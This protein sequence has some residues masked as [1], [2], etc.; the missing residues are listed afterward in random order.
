[1]GGQTVSAPH[2]V[3]LMTAAAQVSATDTVLDIGTA[4]AYHAA[5]PPRLIRDVASV[6]TVPERA[7]QVAR[8]FGMPFSITAAIGSIAL[9]G[10]AML[11]GLMRVDLIGAPRNESDP[12]PID[13]AVRK[14]ARDRLGSVLS[15]ALVASIGFV[16]IANC[17]GGEMQ[18]PLATGV[19][20]GI[21]TSTPPTLLL[22]S[23]NRWLFRGSCASAARGPRN[24]SARP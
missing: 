17:A 11:D 15:T 3:T 2:I 6:E 18:Q 20:L 19:N 13:D 22:P 9:S 8:H 12:R 23:L 4:S 1:M 24:P 14:A 10:I 5:V 21:V 16:Q 7:G